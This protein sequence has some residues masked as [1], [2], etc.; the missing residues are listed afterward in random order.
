MRGAWHNLSPKDKIALYTTYNDQGDAVAV[1]ILSS[2]NNIGYIT[3]V[4][5]L[6]SVRGEGYGKHATYHCLQESVKR[7]NK[8]HCLAT[9]KDTYPY[10]F[11]KRLG[12]KNEFTSVCYVSASITRITASSADMIARPIPI[13]GNES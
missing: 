7:G 2:G 1:S 11:Y 4:G 10:E 8:Y 6:P 3:T 12:F 9:E 5:S 13:P